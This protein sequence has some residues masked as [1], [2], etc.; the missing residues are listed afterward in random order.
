LWKHP[1][2]LDQLSGRIGKLPTI[3]SKVRTTTPPD[4][5]VD[6]PL[7]RNSSDTVADG[8]VNVP[9]DDVLNRLPYGAKCG[10]AVDDLIQAAREFYG[11]IEILYEEESTWVHHDPWWHLYLSTHSS[12]HPAARAVV[13]EIKT[14][15]MEYSEAIATSV[16]MAGHG[17]TFAADAVG[18]YEH[19]SRHSGEDVHL[20][21]N[22]MQQIARLAH[23][24]AKES[25][26]KFSTVRRTFLQV[27][28]WNTFSI[29]AVDWGDP[30]DHTANFT[31]KR[32]G[33]L[34]V[35]WSSGQ[36]L[37]RGGYFRA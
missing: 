34:G 9:L 31:T 2:D 21:M 22:E 18:L 37:A 24:D 3:R 35:T 20:F 30:S 25:Y 32:A 7:S 1:P 13:K 15:A 33:R 26:E 10:V 4:D 5:I 17:A 23:V 16:K 27:C 28:I 19:L 29:G 8:P 11:Q 36:Q 12:G 6:H 14:A